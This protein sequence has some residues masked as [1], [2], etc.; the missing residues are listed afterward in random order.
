VVFSIWS[1]TNIKLSHEIEFLFLKKHEIEINCIYDF[2]LKCL[3]FKD[4]F[5]LHVTWDLTVF[6]TIWEFRTATEQLKE[7]W[8]H[9]MLCSLF[10]EVQLLYFFGFLFQ[11][12]NLNLSS[13]NATFKKTLNHHQKILGQH[14][15]SQKIWQKEKYRILEM[16]MP[17]QCEK[18]NL[19]HNQ[20]QI[21][22]LFGQHE[23]RQFP[24]EEKCPIRSFTEMAEN[25]WILKIF[26]V[27]LG[28]TKPYKFSLY[29]K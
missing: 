6:V 17:K 11:P 15:I 10:F 7:M 21:Q 3:Y 4:I 28:E 8:I 16:H 12:L 5:H 25:S 2:E 9:N 27:N 1:T 23:P 13:K 18:N 20:H 26:R 29:R 24:T 14:L 19:M 22:Q